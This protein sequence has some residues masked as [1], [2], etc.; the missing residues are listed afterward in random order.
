MAGPGSNR[1]PV[2]KPKNAGKIIKRLIKYMSAYRY[3]LILV[4]ILIIVS[5]FAAVAGN[6]FLKPVIN[7]YIVP[8]IGNKNPDLSGLVFILTLMGA[9]YLTGV[10]ASY[11][12]ARIMVSIST[13]TLKKC[14]LIY[15]RTWSHC[16]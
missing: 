10:L 12:Y 9:I 15:L 3:Q 16:L 13:G 4:G 6:Y 11:L 7:N 14:G 1:K 8:F 5:S 2:A